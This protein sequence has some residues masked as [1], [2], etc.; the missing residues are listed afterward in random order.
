[1]NQSPE[2]QRLRRLKAGGRLIDI[3]IAAN[4]APATVRSYE[5]GAP[6]RPAIIARLQAAYEL[7]CGAK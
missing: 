1:M 6:C 2:T 5:F 3:A 7:V 4:C